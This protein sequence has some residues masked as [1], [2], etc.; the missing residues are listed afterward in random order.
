MK[1]T[2]VL[3]TGGK[4]SVFALHIARENGLDVKV[5]A[6]I[7]PHYQYSMLYHQPPYHGILAQ[8][9]SMNIP[10]ETIGLDDPNR[11]IDALRLLVSRIAKRYGVRV[12]VTGAVKSRYQ[13]RAFESIAREIGLE[14][15]APNWGIDD[16]S[17]MRSLINSG[18]EFIIISITSMGIPIDL[19]GRV[20]Q[21]S[22]LERLERLSRK[23][24]F[25]LSFE[26]GEAET[27][28]VNAPFFKYKIDVK[29]SIEV[30]SEFE[31]YYRI[32]RVCL[33]KKQ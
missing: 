1:P 14:L 23:Y 20:I 33:V 2:A 6:S 24:G 11:E 9:Q 21:G 27:F 32:S 29:G 18:I 8:A 19:L 13:Y 28:V 12:L 30:L 15:Y 22:D 26:G 4:D 5:L 16:E 3:Y 17:Y 25:N 10:L 7:I 31:G